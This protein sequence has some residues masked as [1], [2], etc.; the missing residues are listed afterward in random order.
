[1]DR[2]RTRRRLLELEFKGNR[3]MGRPRTRYFSQVLEGKNENEKVNLAVNRKRYFVGTETRLETFRLST[4]I[5]RK[6]VRARRRLDAL[7]F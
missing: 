3:T 2:T 4:C 1:M 7:H 6:S 5:K